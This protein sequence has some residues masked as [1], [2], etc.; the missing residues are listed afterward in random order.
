M[1]FDILDYTGLVCSDGVMIGDTTYDL[2]MAQ[3]AGMNGWGVGYGSHAA[4]HLQPLS[5][6]AVAPGFVDLVDQLI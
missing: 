6:H 2:E 1:L 4:R 3:S 5:T